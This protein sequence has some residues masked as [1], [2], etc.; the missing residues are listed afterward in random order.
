MTR[1]EMMERWREEFQNSYYQWRLSPKVYDYFD[2]KTEQLEGSG[3]LSK[4]YCAYYENWLV[5]ELDGEN[6]ELARRMLL[7][8]SKIRSNGMISATYRMRE[9][10][11]ICLRIG[12]DF[13]TIVK[14]TIV[15]FDDIAANDMYWIAEKLLEC[16]PDETGEYA[17]RVMTDRTKY[18]RK[19]NREAYLA[20]YMAILL[21]KK[22]ATIYAR[23]QPTLVSALEHGGGAYNTGLLYYG[24]SLAPELKAALLTL[25]ETPATVRKLYLLME[26]KDMRPLLQ[27][28]GAPLWPYY[29]LVA[30][31]TIQDIDRDAVL[32]E[33][34]D[35][36]KLLFMETYGYLTQTAQDLPYSLFMQAILLRNGEKLDALRNIRRSLILTMTRLMDEYD[37]Q[38][39]RVS[40]DKLLSDTSNWQGRIDGMH[41]FGRGAARLLIGVLSLFYEYSAL[42]RRFV[43]ILLIQGRGF[44]SSHNASIV[45]CCVLEARKKWLHVSKEDSLRLLLD[46]GGG[47]GFPQIFRAYCYNSSI[48]GDV[49]TPDAVKQHE[50]VALD[51][52]NSGLL[53]VEEMQELLSILYNT[54]KLQDC[55]PLIGLLSNQSKRL[56]KRAEEI[57]LFHEAAARPVL[58]GQLSELKGE[59]LSA[60]KRLLKR[61]DNERKF[62]TNFT[63]TYATVVGYCTD[64]YDTHSS[65]LLSWLPKELF[66]GIRF[67]DLS[68]EAPA[69]VL[70]YIFSE[71]L[72]LK[73]AN[74]IKN[75]DEIVSLLHR[76][77]LQASLEKIYRYWKDNSAHPKKKTIML[78]YCLYASDTQL[79]ALN[80]QLLEWVKDLR[81]Q[82]AS[83][84]VNALALNG[85]KVALR[86]VDDISV[87]FPGEQLRNAAKAAFVF[88]AKA[89]E[90]PEDE[91]LDQI[92]ATEQTQ[93]SRLEKVLMNGRRWTACSWRT[94]FVENPAMHSFTTGLIWGVYKEDGVL[95]DTFR[96][97]S[98]G[99][100][101]TVDG[102]AYALPEQTNITLVHPVELSAEALAQWKEQVD[103][104]GVVQPLPQ[105]T[106][107]VVSLTDT[108]LDGKK[109]LRYS[110][111]ITLSGKIAGLANKY[112]LMRGPVRDGGIFTCFNWVDNYLNVVGQLN[113]EQMRV[114]EGYNTPVTLG[115]V[116]FYRLSEDPRM[117]D[118][119]TDNM[120]LAPS[121][122]PAR[123]V[124]SVLGVFDQLK[125][126]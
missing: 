1:E 79:L 3:V 18:L 102:A 84:V 29:Y 26:K 94:L 53:S 83:F 115:Q 113:F 54:C 45:V 120:M 93:A 110:G 62:G 100:F 9:D 125:Y 31:E 6:N 85:G 51:L 19:D 121:A 119:P 111:I 33:L 28:I 80:S 52:L 47:F 42:A 61:W 71:Y 96:C 65:K 8:L 40:E 46:G 56:R 37:N 109:I 38:K 27:E 14:Q 41:H 63:F 11:C 95:A 10:V 97:N 20:L 112:N 105:L 70:Q 89:L 99:T 69:V 92:E 118:E 88:A 59:G 34:Y 78:P 35:T 116:L 32:S 123:F 82:V 55:P 43:N 58:K 23:Y 49:F 104:S 64:N 101:Y 81:R 72:S 57:L 24:Y 39:R 66:A 44:G 67:A 126:E 17:E 98:D 48:L 50:P 2:E 87:N 76:Q 74:R 16:Y 22:D 36:D 60:A 15:S 122:L 107:P 68:G 91:L 103:N 13:D 108:E 90:I 86:M 7:V 117:N 75:C 5:K 21:L 25:L 77:D 106:T 124:S 4:K 114:G 73:E 30:N 12:Y